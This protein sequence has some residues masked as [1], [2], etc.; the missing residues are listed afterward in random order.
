MFLLKGLYGDSPE[1]SI[2]SISETGVTVV[3]GGTA[4]VNRIFPASPAES[5]IELYSDK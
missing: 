3:L 2:I 5:K 1:I 4:Q